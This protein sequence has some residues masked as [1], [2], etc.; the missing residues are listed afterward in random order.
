MARWLTWSTRSGARAVGALVRRGV[1]GDVGRPSGD[2]DAVGPLA[3]Q[4]GSGDQGVERLERLAEDQHVAGRRGG[5]VDDAERVAREVVADQPLEH[6]AELR[7]DQVAER[8]PQRLVG[9]ETLLQGV[10]P[11]GERAEAVEHRAE[12]GDHVGR[13]RRQLG[14]LQRAQQRL[15]RRAVHG[16]VLDG[17]DRELRRDV[18][19]EEV[20]PRALLDVVEVE[21]P[22]VRR[23]RRGEHHRVLRTA[24]VDRH[25]GRVRSPEVRCT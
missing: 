19:R 12:G 5:A 21:V 3:R 16:D 17:R 10:E 22:Q 25:A 20:L 7:P 9:R 4:A 2:A 1:D 15:E 6:R 8:G 23:V 24:L 11:A 13:R 18:G 14:V